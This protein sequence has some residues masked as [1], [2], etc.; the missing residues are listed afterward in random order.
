MSTLK[1]TAASPGEE[2]RIGEIVWEWV[3]EVDPPPNGV[4]TDEWLE[5]CEARYD[6]LMERT[7]LMKLPE[8]LDD[9]IDAQMVRDGDELVCYPDFEPTMPSP[10]ELD[11]AAMQA[12]NAW[13]RW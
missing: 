11:R 4:E 6:E 2:L 8:A 7:P 5:R 10:W 3:C 9:R 1:S 13:G 12:E